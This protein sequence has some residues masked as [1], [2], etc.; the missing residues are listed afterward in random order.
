MLGG[1][2]KTPNGLGKEFLHPCYLFVG[3]ELLNVRRMPILPRIRELRKIFAVFRLLLRK[4]RK[5]LSGN[6]VFVPHS[7]QCPLTHLH[8]STWD[9]DPV[10]LTKP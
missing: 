5:R 9:V 7:S 1:S 3:P 2:R 6:A 4:R 8:L 10:T